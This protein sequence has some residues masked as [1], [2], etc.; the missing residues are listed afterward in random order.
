MQ[1]EKRSLKS[2]RWSHA[3]TMGT[4][5]AFA[6]ARE[7][8]ARKK[9][10]RAKG[11]N[12]KACHYREFIISTVH[13]SPSRLSA[14]KSLGIKLLPAARVLYCLSFF[15]T[16]KRSGFGNY[17][18]QNEQVDVHC[19]LFSKMTVDLEGFFPF[20]RF[21]RVRVYVRLNGHVGVGQGASASVRVC[22]SACK[23]AAILSFV[24]IF[25]CTC[26]CV[27]DSVPVPVVISKCSTFLAVISQICQSASFAFLLLVFALRT[28]LRTDC[29][30]L[31]SWMLVPRQVDR[32]GRISV[33]LRLFFFCKDGSDRMMNRSF[34]SCNFLCVF[35]CFLKYRWYRFWCF[36][37]VSHFRLSHTH[38]L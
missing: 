10:I 6:S 31:L 3:R 36:P 4:S 33:L 20:R 2:F 1:V 28:G 15:S 26:T 25:L 21:K 29:H 14:G 16:D 30:L 37:F 32:M 7:A 34:Y 27:C 35:S 12:W 11:H 23:R 18:I 9:N 13:P 22:V 8:H 19:I 17:C 5:T 24:Y 38:W